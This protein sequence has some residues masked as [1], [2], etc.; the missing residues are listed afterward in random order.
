[1]TNDIKKY[2]AF[3]IGV[4]ITVLLVCGVGGYFMTRD[5]HVTIK[6]AESQVRLNTG[7]GAIAQDKE[8]KDK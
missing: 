5:S 1:M 3:I 8:L 2:D 4:I 7:G 6:P